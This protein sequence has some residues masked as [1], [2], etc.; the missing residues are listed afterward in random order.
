MQYEP[1]E[2]D[3]VLLQHKFE[4]ENK[5]G[6]TETR[7]STLLDYGAPKGYSAMAKLVGVPCGIA[8]KQV[9][10]GTISETGVLAPLTPEMNDPLMAELREHGIWLT[11]RTV[12]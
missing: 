2:R 10:N 7:T 3:M 11:E 9:L 6:S 12:V 1:G 5:D 4:I 8:V